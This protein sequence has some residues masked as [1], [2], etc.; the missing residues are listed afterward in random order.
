MWAKCALITDCWGKVPSTIGTLV[1]DLSSP[2][3]EARIAKYA[4]GL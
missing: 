1:G 3:V 2:P 4:K